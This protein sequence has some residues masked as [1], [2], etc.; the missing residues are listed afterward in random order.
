VFNEGRKRRSRLVSRN[1]NRYNS[2]LTVAIAG[3]RTFYV[4]LFHTGT[5]RYYT[6]RWRREMRLSE[7]QQGGSAAV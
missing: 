3:L 1:Y 5:S 7:W 4:T 2:S 6:S